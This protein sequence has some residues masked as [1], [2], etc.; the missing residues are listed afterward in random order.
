[1]AALRAAILTLY[2]HPKKKPF[3]INETASA[4]TVLGCSL[5]KQLHAAKK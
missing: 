5:Y 4:F 1:M 3:Q 2:E